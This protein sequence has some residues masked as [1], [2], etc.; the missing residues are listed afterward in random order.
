M[1]K[2]I[3][4][5]YPKATLLG[6]IVLFTLL[7]LSLLEYCAGKFF[8]LGKTV[9]YEAHSVYGYRPEPNQVVARQPKQII[10]I[11]NLGLRAQEN[12]DLN[13]VQN[14]ILFLGD[15]VTYGGSYLSNDELFSHLAVKHLSGY[16]A[17]NAGVNGWGVNNVHALV[18]EMGFVP[19][20]IYVSLFPE[21][22]FYRGLMR[23]GGQPFWTRKPKYALEELFQY[24]IYQIH[25]KKMPPIHAC[26][27]DEKQKSHIVELAAKNLKELDD[28]LKANGKTHLIYISPSR[29][30]LL[31]HAHTDDIVKNALEKYGLRVTYLKDKI[32]NQHPNDIAALF[33]DEIHLSPEGHQYWA[34]LISSDLQQIIPALS[35]NKENIENKEKINNDNQNS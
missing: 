10:K 15:S 31:H 23:I 28:F 34:K 29:S 7:T 6:V 9:I 17:G 19:A 27:L 5:H 3:F 16:Q 35:E 21:G 18:K 11:N 20:Q 12:W 2:T 25:I 26:L 13:D 24:G 8:G 30:Q 4:E 22:D 32:E 14:K 33:H 1:P